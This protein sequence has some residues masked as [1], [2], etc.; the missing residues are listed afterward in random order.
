LPGSLAR[1]PCPAALPG[2]LARQPCPAAL[3][4]SSAAFIL[5]LAE[6]RQFIASYP[7]HLQD[8]AILSLVYKL[9]ACFVRVR[10]EVI[11][12]LVFYERSIGKVEHE[13]C[14]TK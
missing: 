3:P 11:F 10:T 14:T 9:I 4:G 6:V 12:S 5:L 13:S 2:S 7:R 8:I 1:Q